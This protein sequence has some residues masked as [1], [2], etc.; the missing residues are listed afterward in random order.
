M[1]IFVFL[2]PIVPSS[3]YLS[4]ESKKSF[5]PPG[6]P[7]TL[8]LG[9]ASDCTEPPVLIVAIYYRISSFVNF[10]P[11]APNALGLIADLVTE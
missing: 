5:L 1:S 9:K 4:I 2:P 8:L 11:E 3:N 6:L 10:Y 7:V